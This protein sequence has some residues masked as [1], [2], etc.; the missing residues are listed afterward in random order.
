MEAHFGV[1]ASPL[2][3][4][5]SVVFEISPRPQ[6]IRVTTWGIITSMAYGLWLLASRKEEAQAMGE[7]LPAMIVNDAISRVM[8]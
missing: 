2:G 6:V 7:P 8:D 3:F 4:S 1:S 5:I